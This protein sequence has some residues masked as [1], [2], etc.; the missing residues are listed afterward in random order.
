[1]GRQE[2]DRQDEEGK[3]GSVEWEALRVQGSME[4]GK[5]RIAIDVEQRRGQ[6]GKC[7]QGGQAKEGMG[8]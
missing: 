8:E 4:V 1:M 7:M 5:G 6:G 2:A 3:E